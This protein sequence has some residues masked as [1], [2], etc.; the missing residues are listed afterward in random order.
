MIPVK[1]LE[2]E[3]RL[4]AIEYLLSHI[5]AGIHVAS[6]ATMEKVQLGHSETLDNLR[7]KP[8]TGFDPA[9]SDLVSGELENAVARLLDMQREMM[10]E[11]LA[12]RGIG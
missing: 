6:G 1:E 11:M 9:T 2:L 4:S 12:K 3:M 10:A 7:R 5:Y 8:L